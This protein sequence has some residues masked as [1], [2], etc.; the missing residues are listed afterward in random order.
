MPRL[1]TNY[2][3]S[4]Y[5]IMLLCCLIPALSFGLPQMDLALGHVL[6]FWCFGAHLHLDLLLF[7]MITAAM[8]ILLQKYKKSVVE[9]SMTNYIQYIP[10]LGIYIGSFAIPLD[11]DVYWQY[12]PFL[13]LILSCLF[14]DIG[15][16]YLVSKK[17]KLKST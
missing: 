2:I 16:I 7:G 10:Y 17:R 15:R 9:T 6:I 13:S 3:Y 8:V 14:T 5:T 11:W 12:F 1:H 4:D